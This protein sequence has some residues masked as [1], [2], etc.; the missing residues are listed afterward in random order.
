MLS[1]EEQ[2]L[3]KMPHF[4]HHFKKR[5]KKLK[6]TFNSNFPLFTLWMSIKL[7]VDT[8]LSNWFVH[9]WS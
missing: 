3:L 5:K 4:L 9:T 7:N 8:H 6:L 2:T 1:A